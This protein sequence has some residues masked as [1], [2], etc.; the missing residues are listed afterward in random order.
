MHLLD[1]IRTRPYIK[2]RFLVLVKHKECQCLRGKFIE[3]H[4]NSNLAVNKIH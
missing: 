2:K 1:P 3:Y 4:Q